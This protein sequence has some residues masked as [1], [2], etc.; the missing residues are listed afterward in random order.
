MRA[1]DTA[2]SVRPERR[3]R[4]QEAQNGAD[5][6]PVE[7]R[8]DDA[9]RGEKHERLAVGFQMQGIVAHKASGARPD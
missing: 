5:A 1:G 8:H 2:E 4:N 7:Q 6:Q 3:A 9:R